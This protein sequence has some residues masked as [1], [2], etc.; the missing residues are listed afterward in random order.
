MFVCVINIAFVRKTPETLPA[1]NKPHIAR[2]G[3]MPQIWFEKP[4]SRIKLR[5]TFNKWYNFVR[6]HDYVERMWYSQGCLYKSRI[7]QRKH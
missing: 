6:S 1:F 2:E 4:F 7:P 3:F 5:R